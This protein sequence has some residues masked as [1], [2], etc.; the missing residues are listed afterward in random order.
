MAIIIFKKDFK[1]SLNL[2]ASRA[3]FIC[4]HSVYEDEILKEP[5]LNAFLNGHSE[6]EEEKNPQTCKS[7]ILVLHISIFTITLEKI[8]FEAR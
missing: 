8:G 5:Q 4:L 3:V 2:W 7:G 6:K 1:T